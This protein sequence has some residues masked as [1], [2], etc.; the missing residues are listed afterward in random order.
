M[1]LQAD[2]TT[3]HNKYSIETII[4]EGA[5]GRVYK[6]WDTTLHRPVAI[7]ELRADA[8]QFDEYARRFRREAQ[9]Q[10]QFN[11]PHL[12]HVYELIDQG[13]ALYLVMEYVDGSTLHDALAQRGPLPLDEAVRITLEV[14]D[15]LAVVHE[16]KLGIVHRDIKPSNI[17]LTAQGQA[18]LTDFGLAQVEG[19]GE[20]SLGQPHPGAPLYKSPE[21]ETTT[22]Y[23]G[24]ASDI[25]S[26]GLVLAEML[27]GQLYK[28]L[29]LRGQRVRD[30]RPEVPPA[31]E[32]VVCKAVAEDRQARY[33]SATEMAVALKRVKLPT[34]A[35]GKP[36]I[37]PYLRRRLLVT[38]VGTAGLV[39][40]VAAVVAGIMALGGQHQPT[41]TQVVLAPTNTPSATM[42]PTDTP[43]P[44]MP[45][46]TPQPTDTPMPTSTP[47]PPTSTPKPTPTKT[48]VP[49]TATPLGGGRRIAFAS[50]RD[51]NDEIYV[52]N[53]DGS[54]LKNLTNNPAIDYNPAWSPDGQRIVFLSDRTGNGDIYV[55]NADGSKVT[56][57]TDTPAND[58]RPC[59]SPDG[60]RIAFSSERDG[61][62]EIYVMNADGSE[63]KN[64]TNNPDLDD[65]PSWS[66][67]GQRIAFVS[68]RDGSRDIYTMSADGSGVTRLTDSKT[69]QWR[70]SWSPDG[71]HIIFM[72][73]Y[74]DSLQ[75]DIHVM[76]ADGSR[77][78]SLT[79][80]PADDMDPTWSPDGRHIAFVSERDGNMEIYVMN[81]D[82]N[83]QNR[84]TN[85]PADDESPAWSPR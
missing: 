22:R 4:G 65:D 83:G 51:G 57:L 72:Y 2:S 13:D 75:W 74:G 78:M 18:K 64:L 42:L 45:T 80:N 67:N 34:K 71:T 50:N 9:V 25:Y 41:P 46:P 66:P 10:A 73:Y 16:H 61:N 5:F 1:P 82:G 59:W 11:H 85:N 21:A 33:Q 28:P 29:L 23:L 79:N 54:E 12:V 20:I 70:P 52:M 53:A 84:L 39:I 17:L 58:R 77:Q 56:R 37:P 8:A 26:L 35:R 14:L 49:L 31:L 27:V 81:T 7:K 63:Q 69:W 40:L 15:G 36:L 24:P 43:A 60:R 47:P 55:M 62:W 38:G 30:L 32:A 48:R 19:E 6:A 76:N 68:G 44:P 3:I